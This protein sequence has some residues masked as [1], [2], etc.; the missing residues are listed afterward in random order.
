VPAMSALAAA[1]V[2]VSRARRSCATTAIWKGVTDAAQAVR[3]RSGEVGCSI[4]FLRLVTL[5]LA[6]RFFEKTLALEFVVTDGA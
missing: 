5:A 1:M 4:D 3:W 6:D 2:A